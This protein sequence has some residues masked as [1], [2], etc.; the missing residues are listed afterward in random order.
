MNPVSVS[1]G[2]EKLQ[3]YN[4][5]F[6]KAISTFESVILVLFL[7]QL[8]QVVTFRFINREYPFSVTLND[9]FTGDKIKAW[10]S[11]KQLSP[12]TKR[13]IRF[14]HNNAFSLGLMLSAFLFIQIYFPAY[15]WEVTTV[16][17]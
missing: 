8:I 12:G 15:T 13:K 17:N 1:Q 11:K 14:I 9:P 3:G 5:G 4:A 10:G 6:E 2:V 7:T 16:W